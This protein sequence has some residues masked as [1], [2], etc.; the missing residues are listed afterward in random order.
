MRGST[1]GLLVSARSVPRFQYPDAESD[2]WSPACKDIMAAYKRGSRGPPGSYEADAE[3][4]ANLIQRLYKGEAIPRVS[5]VFAST[6]WG[7]KK[8]M[9]IRPGLGSHTVSEEGAE[10]TY[11][12]WSPTAQTQG[13]M[14]AQG[15]AASRSRGPD[16]D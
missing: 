4:S 7:G 12:P 16:Q 6:L 3:W 15:G 10:R 11:A 1:T 13:G 8:K 5:V 14:Q 9:E 2:L